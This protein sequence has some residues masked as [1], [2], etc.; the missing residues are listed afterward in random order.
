[1]LSCTD[2]GD[3]V[4]YALSNTSNQPIEI[5]LF[6][7]YGIN[8]TAIINHNEFRVMDQDKAPYD[9]N[10]FGHYDSIRIYFEDLKI[11]TYHSSEANAGCIHADKTPFCFYS[12][13]ACLNDICMF[14]IDST[15]YQKAK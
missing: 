11:L 15:E 2:Q 13:Y 5:V 4:Y 9:V 1:M 7:R 3:P 10:P 6:E 14:E 12:N 8:D